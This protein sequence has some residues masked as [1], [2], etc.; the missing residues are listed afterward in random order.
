MEKKTFYITTTLPY[1]NDRP[2]IG[3]ALEVIQADTLARYKRLTGYDVFLNFGTDE[4][5]QKI[6]TSSQSAGQEPQIFADFYAETFKGLRESLSFSYDKFIRTTDPDH[7]LAAQEMWRRCAA[8]GDIYTKNYSVKYCV[9]CEM[10]KTDSELADNRCP[11]HPSMEIEIHD[12]ENYFFA[13]SKY[14]DQ[15]LTLWNTD[16]F[17]VPDHRLNELRAL[18]QEKGLQDFSISRLASKMSWGVP[19]P[20]DPGH[21]M[22]VWFDA[23]VNYISTLGW[24]NDEQNF[25]KFWTR[26][27]NCVQFAGKDQMRPQAAMWQAILLSAGLPTTGQICIHGFINVDGQKMSK[28]VGNVIDP[29]SLVSEYGTDAL[30]YHLLRHTHPFEDSDMNMEKFHE[31]YTAHLVNGLGNLTARI[32]TLSGQYCESP[33]ETPT[34]YLERELGTE[35]DEYRFDHAMDKIWDKIGELD[36]FIT[37]TEPFKIVKNDLEQGKHLISSSVKNLAEIAKLLA[38]FMPSTSSTILQHILENKK[39]ITPIF[40]RI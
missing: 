11:I 7:K 37:E 25:N 38:P 13:F 27:K 8:N 23:L 20:D 39:P 24:P 29:L 18:V 6:L 14:T 5:G 31:L 21:V 28:S 30:R 9:G 12:E 33:S 15:L 35:F 32:L 1:V 17:V 4:H 36:T 16:G 40:P 10:E 3:H 22:Y 2:H 26:E 19:V 34:V